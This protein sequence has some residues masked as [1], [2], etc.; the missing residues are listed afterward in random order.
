[1]EGHERT[2]Q[3]CGSS[4]FCSACVHRGA[5]SI[6][7]AQL[8]PEARPPAVGF[9]QSLHDDGPTAAYAFYYWNMPNVPTTNTTLRLAIAPVYADAQ[10]GFKGLLGENTDLA[11]GVFG[12][13]F[14]NRLQKCGKGITTATKA[15]MAMAVAP[16][17]ASSIFS[18]PGESSIE[19]IVRAGGNYHVFSEPPIPPIISGF[20]A[21]SRSILCTPA[22]AGVA[23]SPCSPH[24]GGGAFRRYDLRTG[25][26]RGLRL[27]WRRLGTQFRFSSIP[28]HRPAHLHDA[29][30]GTLHRARSGGRGRDQCRPF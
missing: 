20:Q 28:R 10:L 7:Y 3:T 11:V 15:S 9:N 8:D 26:T 13:G 25:R 30:L 17:S 24:A 21:T 18:I 29:A 22:Y 19:R 23:R 16:P 12:G 14:Y 1:M 27:Q 5:T 4:N 6:G 2:E